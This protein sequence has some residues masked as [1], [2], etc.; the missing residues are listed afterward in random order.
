MPRRLLTL[1]YRGEFVWPDLGHVLEAL[2]SRGA[3]FTA[4][5]PR[6]VVALPNLAR[7]HGYDLHAVDVEPA[8]VARWLAPGGVVGGSNPGSAA[9]AHLFQ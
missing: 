8:E 1:G 9:P 5:H 2:A 6:G 4:S 3:L 7:D